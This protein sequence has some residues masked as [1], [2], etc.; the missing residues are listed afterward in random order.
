[1]EA[2]PRTRFERSHFSECGDFSLNFE[3]VYYMLDPDYNIYMDTQEAINLEIFR[4]FKEG[5]IKFAYPTQVVHV[6][7]S[8]TR[9]NGHEREPDGERAVTRST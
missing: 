1:V 5:G 8:A 3:S 7:S 9:P 6:N 4:R 2:Q